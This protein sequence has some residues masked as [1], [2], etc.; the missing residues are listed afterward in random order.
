MSPA[1]C[2]AALAA[3]CMLAPALALAG[4]GRVAADV[5][6]V[7]RS[8]ST[9]HAHLVLL[10]NEEGGVTCNGGATHHL[11]DPQ[12]VH[13]RAIQEDLKSSADSHLVLAPRPGS[14]FSYAVRDADGSVSFGD[15]SP[16]QPK[17][18]RELALFVLTTA[19]QVCGLPE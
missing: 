8:G 14:V 9:P 19:Q 18:L 3:C 2:A 17:V 16:N 15:N 4:C 12:L 5:F 7:T 6:I 1:R 11:S 13:A 10:V